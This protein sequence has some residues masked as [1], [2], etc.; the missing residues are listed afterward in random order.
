MLFPTRWI[1]IA[2]DVE[3]PGRVRIYT[4]D[5]KGGR[6]IDEGKFNTNSKDFTYIKNIADVSDNV[7]FFF[8][9]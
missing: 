5:A 8:C 7:A 9:F 2:A 4:Y 6:T 3:V 1:E